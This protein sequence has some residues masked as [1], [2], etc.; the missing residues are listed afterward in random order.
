MSLQFGIHVTNQY[1]RGSIMVRALD[2]QLLFLRYARNN[3]WHSAWVGQHFLFDKL[4]QLNPVPFLARL[5]AESGHMRLRMRRELRIKQL[6]MRMQTPGTPADEALRS[7]RLLT[8]EVMTTES[9][10]AP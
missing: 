7:M 2:E 6:V 3:G 5:A 1:P 4:S 8:E 10:D 9:G